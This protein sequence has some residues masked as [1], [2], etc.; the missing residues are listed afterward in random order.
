M[1]KLVS[2]NLYFMGILKED[3]W[4]KVLGELEISLS[5]A[6]FLTWFQK[7]Y[8]IAKKE[9]SAVIS[10][11]N[12]F[13]KE[14]LEAKYRKPLL[15][16]LRTHDN[17]IKDLQFVIGKHNVNEITAVKDSEKHFSPSALSLPLQAAQVNKGTNL[18]P[19]FTF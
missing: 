7:T 3:L 12:A 10:V 8:L 13:V 1:R 17:E 14:W 19:R 15:K 6:N 16:S 18:N 11:P 4:Q 5:R 2:L 9:G